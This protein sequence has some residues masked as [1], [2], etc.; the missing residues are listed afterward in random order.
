ML[1]NTPRRSSN[2]QGS[3]HIANSSERKFS[4]FGQKRVGAFHE[5]VSVEL[6][7]SAP[8]HPSGNLLRLQ[9]H[10]VMSGVGIVVWFVVQGNYTHPFVLTCLQMQI[11]VVQSQISARKAR[12]TPCFEVFQNLLSANKGICAH[13]MVA[14]FDLRFHWGLETARLCAERCSCLWSNEM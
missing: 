2:I 6:E 3:Q 12:I 4:R 11:T 8:Q 5:M 1:A 14:I 10:K 7:P 13:S 9:P